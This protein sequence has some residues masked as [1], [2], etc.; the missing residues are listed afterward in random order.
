MS[1]SGGR[2]TGPIQPTDRG[3][4]NP[5]NTPSGTSQTDTTD[6]SGELVDGGREGSVDPAFQLMAREIAPRLAIPRAR[7][8]SVLRRGTGKLGSAHYSGGSDE[9]DLDATLEQ[10]VDH[11]F[12]TEADIVVRERRQARRSVALV[13]DVSGSMRGERIKLAA[14]TVGAVVGRLSPTTDLA[15]VAFWSDAALLVPLGEHVTP[16][17]VLDRLLRLPARG[18]TNVDFPLQVA[19]QQLARIPVQD[20]RVLLLSDCVHNAGPDPRFVAGKLPRLDVLLDA[21][22]EHDTDLG[23]GLARVSRG[24]L[25]VARNHRDV[26]PALNRI[27]KT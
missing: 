12:P 7:L 19:S 25:T 1:A 21:S 4:P 24:H 17:E 11:P 6:D 18:L 9:I 27:F 23:G 26:G 16:Q 8:D 3:G 10:L 15:V 13:V 20:A 14:A 22:G 5:V 2:G